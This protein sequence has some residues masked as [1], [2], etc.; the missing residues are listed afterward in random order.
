MSDQLPAAVRTAPSQ[1]P[2]PAPRYAWSIPGFV[3]ER[4]GMGGPEA[5]CYTDRW[6]YSPGEEVH[7]H[8]HTTAETYTLTL[9]RD[10][11]TPEVVWSAIGLPGRAHPTPSDAYAVGCGWPVAHTFTIDQR[12]KPGFYILIIGIE[13]DGRRHE[14]EHFLIVRN[15]EPGVRT[16]YVLVLTTSTMTAYN[17][18]G[19]AN[20]Y[21]GLGDDPW[22]DVAGPRLSVQRPI[23]R[24]MI[25]KPDEAPRSSNPDTPPRG[26]LPRH[27]AYEWAHTH[28][29]SRHHAD[30]FWATYERPFALWA[31]KEGIEFDVLTQHDLHQ[32]PG[33]LTPY[34]CAIFVG[35]DEYWTAQMRDSVDA[36]VDGGGHLARFGRNFLWQVRLEEDDQVQVNYKV[37]QDDPL[38]DSDPAKVTTAWDWPP[39]DRPAAATMGLTGLS[40]TYNR[41]GSAISRSS[42]GFTVY[43]PRHWALQDTD[44]GYG[45]VFGGAPICIAA[46]ELDGCDYTFRRGLP[47][48]TGSDGTPDNLEIIAMCPATFGEEDRWNGQVPL[49]APITEVQGILGLLFDPLP[50][51]FDGE[52]YGSGMVAEFTRGRGGVFCAG[53]TEWVNG[54]RL[55]DEFTEQITRNVLRRYAVRG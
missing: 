2:A 16:P 39:I 17:D 46:F 42:G 3:V 48:P 37:P 40:G 8:T 25:R 34:A 41:Y 43:R 32:D 31:E 11:L 9:V 45:D 51:R 12:W 55:H 1:S 15:P 5:W 28:G 23:A 47:F 53:T 52:A 14:R 24:G 13:V 35:H 4:P 10:G 21:R 26:A 27:P 20:A 29:Y 7:V 18:W 50:D 54:L 33:C 49:G 36:F 30:A 6:T 38:F 19:G 22:T 44:L